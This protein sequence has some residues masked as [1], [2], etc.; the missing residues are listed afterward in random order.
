MLTGSHPFGSATPAGTVFKITNV[1]PQ[2]PS[3]I[4]ESIS[5][6][7]ESLVMRAL[8]KKRTQRIADVTIFRHYLESL[9][10]AKIPS[11][12]VIKALYKQ[13]VS[14]RLA[15][16]AEYSGPFKPVVDRLSNAKE[17][18]G[19]FI[20]AHRPLVERVVNALLA[21]IMLSFFMSKT[22]FYAEELT[23]IIPYAYCALAIVF[24]RLGLAGGFLIL[25]LPIADYSLVITVFAGIVVFLGLL[26]FWLVRP[27]K[28]VFTVAAP[29]TSMAGFGLAFPLVSGLWWKPLWAAAAAFLGCFMVEFFDLF[30]GKTMNY[31]ALANSFGLKERLSGAINPLTAFPALIKPFIASPGLLLQ[32][33]LWASAAFLISVLT[34]RKSVKRDLYGLFAGAAVLL[35]GQF[36]LM[37][38]FGWNPGY[39]DSLLKTFTASFILAIGLLV[40]LPRRSFTDDED[41]EDFEEDD[42]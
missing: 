21:M 35:I 38:A 12:K 8:D 3:E 18:A 25:L 37:G 30:T 39:I 36:A 31:M 32:P 28:T 40:I 17:R 33:L 27:S 19:E 1:E 11:R 42:S 2:P 29:L 24:P 10:S 7:L 41:E 16:V 5:L 22:G 15:P 6:D 23:A 34:K 14:D 20:A 13:A 4:N 9:R 26:S